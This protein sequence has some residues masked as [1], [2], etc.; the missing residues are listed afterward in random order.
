MQ[1]PKRQRGRPKSQFTESSAGT[2][3]SLD[4]ALS[5]LV[6]L[7]RAGR[8]TLSDLALA[9][10][11]PTATTHRILMTLQ[12]HDFVAFDEDRQDWLIGIEA[13][14]TG[15]AFLKR[16]NLVEI[17]RPVMQL[18][19][20]E[21]G[22]TANLAV[23]QKAEVVFVGQIETLNPIRA[24]FPP[25]TR[26]AMHAS[27]T[28]KAILADLPE[29]KVKRL[30]SAA[31]L[32]RFTANTRTTPADL[33]ADLARTRARGWSFDREERYESMSCIGATIFDEMGN[34][35]A[36]VSISG[37]SIRFDED[38]IAAFGTAVKNAADEITRRLGGLPPERA[39]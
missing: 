4:R 30:L 11:V 19:M 23:P 29:D 22:E 18:L 17:G 7:S 8:M 6:A 10:G 34:P 5:V 20:E 35:C 24:F 38:R 37:P 33:F 15:A 13:F 36:G 3:Q 31:G 1:A 32:E 25:G 26:T 28:G 16:S 12:K 9:V 14:R 2:L 39:R 21:T 27:G